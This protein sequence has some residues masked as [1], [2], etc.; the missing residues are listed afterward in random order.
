MIGVLGLLPEPI[1]HCIQPRPADIFGMTA[2][3]LYAVGTLALTD[4]DGSRPVLFIPTF[5]FFLIIQG[6]W[7][8]FCGIVQDNSIP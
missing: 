5:I 8:T 4:S 2:L 7:S 1:Q 6:G 3:S